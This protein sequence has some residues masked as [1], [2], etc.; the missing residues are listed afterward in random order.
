MNGLISVWLSQTNTSCWYQFGPQSET[1]QLTDPI[2]YV[3]DTYNYTSYGI[4]TA[5]TGTDPNPFR[6]GGQVGYY[7]GVNGLILCGARWYDPEIGRW[8]TRDPIGYTG[9]PNLYEYVASNPVGGIDPEGTQTGGHHFFPEA[10]FNKLNISEEVRSVFNKAL[11]GTIP[12]E[13][14]EP[15]L[16]TFDRAHREYNSTVKELYLN[17]LGHRNSLELTVKEAEE[18]INVIKS[19]N[20]PI[21]RNFLDRISKRMAD[22]AAKKMSNN[23]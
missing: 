23:R 15:L 5:S 6:Y 10:I 1:R 13:S 7:T 17:W 19:S 3:A 22:H 20:N 18:F 4:P 2:G 21:I 8:L 9:G 11:T 16:N 12:V 14:G